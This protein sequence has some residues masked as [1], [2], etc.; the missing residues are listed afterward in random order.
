MGSE[1]RA[2]IQ[3]HPDHIDD[4]NQQVEMI[5]SIINDSMTSVDNESPSSNPNPTITENNTSVEYEP[6]IHNSSIDPAHLN[7]GRTY[8]LMMNK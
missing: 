3:A 8:R 7:S 5:F 2:L 4:I 6:S 1:L